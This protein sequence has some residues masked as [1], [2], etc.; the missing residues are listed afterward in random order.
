MKWNKTKQTHIYDAGDKLLITEWTRPAM[1]GRG[2]CLSN[3]AKIKTGYHYN[4]SGKGHFGDADHWCVVESDVCFMDGEEKMRDRFAKE[5]RMFID[6]FFD[7]NRPKQ[8][9]E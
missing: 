5:L 7:K 8:V 6:D 2:C 3:G 4:G 1:G 9:Y